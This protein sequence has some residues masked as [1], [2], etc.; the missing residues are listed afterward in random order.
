M[1][2]LPFFRASALNLS[3]SFAV[4][5]G[6][7]HFGSEASIDMAGRW[8]YWII[9]APFACLAYQIARWVGAT[10][11]RNV[12][13]DRSS[14]SSW[15]SVRQLAAAV[16]SGR[17]FPL[18][19]VL[20][21]AAVLAC[22][23][24]LGFKVV[25]DEPVMAA[26]SLQMHREKTAFYFTEVHE[27]Q[28]IDYFSTGA[29][30]KRPL[31]FPFLLSLL[32]DLTGYRPLQGV[33]LNLA[34]LPLFLGLVFWMG[35]LLARP[36]GGYLAVAL[37][38]T[39]PLIAMNACG[40]GFDL[41]NLVMLLAVGWSAWAYLTKPDDR[42]MNIC[43]LL[44]VL[45]AQTR[46]ESVLFVFPV[47]TCILIVWWRQREIRITRT[48]VATPLMLIGYA[49]QRR[50]LTDYGQHW[51]LRE[52]YE[53]PF[54]GAYVLPN[55]EHALNFFLSFGTRQ[56]N[57]LVLF[58]GF[59][60]AITAG[61][62]GLTVR[63]RF[64]TALRSNGS[65]VCCGFALVVLLNFGLLMAYHWGQLDDI[66][67]TRL[68]M[69][70]LLLQLALVLG[71]AGLWRVRPGFQL[72]FICIAGLCFAGVTRP[73]LGRT[74]FL[75]AS[76]MNAKVERLVELSVER[77]D[78]P[79][80]LLS[81]RSVAG[82]I[83]LKSSLDVNGVLSQLALLDLHQ[84]LGTFSDIFLV[85]FVFTAAADVEG[86]PSLEEA[87]ALASRIEANFDLEPV[88]DRQLNEAVLLRT[89][90][91]Q[92]VRVAPDERLALSTDG[93]SISYTGKMSFSDERIL[94]TFFETLPK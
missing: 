35:N 40:A 24:P 51:Q 60:L 9:F 25:M 39:S 71:V 86:L 61:F 7:F 2:K 38:A 48:L 49:W 66:I 6:F 63:K 75:E 84:R 33:V 69:P 17:V 90:R 58:L 77:S 94:Q 37:L 19:Y 73:L 21:V 89:S 32:H 59:V 65:I 22:S 27:I 91:V 43:L 42:R 80:L 76:L 23:Q 92:R 82:A 68:A 36:L 53:T 78:E 31:F 93:M 14:G 41:L 54:S 81:D 29:V 62:V 20:L 8:G 83:G 12:E 13:A 85:Y 87:A 16:L 3:A 47:A 50:I 10:V 4:Y 72:A 56:P 79:I 34:L 44:T 57:S 18:L 26:T 67:A 88:S 52:G 5:F 28:N 30:D 74:D 70:L 45:L 1:S 15:A 11:R 46:Y 55:L 64:R